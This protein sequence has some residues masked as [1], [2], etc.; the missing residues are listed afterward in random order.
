ME[1]LL[2][3]RIAAINA[4][5]EGFDAEPLRTFLLNIPE[6]YENPDGVDEW[7]AT[8]AHILGCEYDS[9]PKQVRQAVKLMCYCVAFDGKEITRGD[10]SVFTYEDQA[11][12]THGA[13]AEAFKAFRTILQG[14]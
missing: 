5:L 14:G 8:A 12:L 3:A 11:T 1:S 10:G 4:L 6:D 7:Q 9:V 2:P 13:V